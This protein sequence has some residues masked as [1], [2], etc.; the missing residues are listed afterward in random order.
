MMHTTIPGAARKA[1]NV[2]LDEA[3]LVEAKALR[4]NIS[5]AAEAGLAHA[6]AERRAAQWLEENRGALDSSNAYVEQH[7]LP[8]AQFRNF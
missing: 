1:T 8:L 7:G 4:I 3:L 5:Q 2:T 6:V